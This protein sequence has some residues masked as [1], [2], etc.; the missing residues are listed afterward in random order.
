M[1]LFV[2]G[3]IGVFVANVV[4]GWIKMLLLLP[5]NGGTPEGG[6]DGVCRV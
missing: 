1:R 5:I 3:I 6:T 4:L 2:D